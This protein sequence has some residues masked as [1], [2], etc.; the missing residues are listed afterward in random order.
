MIFIVVCKSL[1]RKKNINMFVD[2][3]SLSITNNPTNETKD[4]PKDAL[5][6]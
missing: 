4:A 5:D 3:V 2:L 6:F 1:L